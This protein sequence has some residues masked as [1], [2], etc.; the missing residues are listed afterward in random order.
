MAAF[1]RLVRMVTRTFYGNAV[2]P[3]QELSSET[4]KKRQEKVCSI[5][6]I[7]LSAEGAFYSAHTH[8][9]V[10]PQSSNKG[11][12]VVIVD[13]LTRRKWTKASFTRMSKTTCGFT[14]PQ[15]NGLC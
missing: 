11:A 4:D 8:L 1:Q 10:W 7:S 9:I 6:S 12:A 2:P 15:R 5:P 3:Q 14:D 13:A